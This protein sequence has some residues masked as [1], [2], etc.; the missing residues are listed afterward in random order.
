MTRRKI[1]NN[2]VIP[3]ITKKEIDDS[4]SFS[5]F[6]LSSCQHIISISISYCLYTFSLTSFLHHFPVIFS[7]LDSWSWAVAAESLSV[8]GTLSFPNISLLII[9]ESFHFFFPF[10][11]KL[12]NYWFLIPLL[13]DFSFLVASSFQLLISFFRTT[14][15]SFSGTLTACP[16]FSSPWYSY[17]T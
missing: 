15:G 7:F 5:S 1:T 13:I 9:L 10:L 3:K 4:W 16:S 14:L 2:P 8:T 11:I 12:L 17:R 6:L